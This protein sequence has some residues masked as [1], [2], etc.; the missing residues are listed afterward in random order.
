MKYIKQIIAHMSRSELPAVLT[1]VC[2]HIAG[3]CEK[4]LQS[5]LQ[6][7]PAGQQAGLKYDTRV[8]Q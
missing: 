4:E 5:S 2:T 8:H 7:V 6:G 3:R 1:Q